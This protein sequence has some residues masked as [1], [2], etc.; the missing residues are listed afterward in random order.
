M[1]DSLRG[2]WQSGKNLNQKRAGHSEDV[3]LSRVDPQ[4]RHDEFVF[5]CAFCNF[6]GWR[7]AVPCYGQAGRRGAA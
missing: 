3:D 6:D 4:S 1:Y 7:F 2:E 5:R